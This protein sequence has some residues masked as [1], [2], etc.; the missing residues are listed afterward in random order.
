MSQESVNF[1]QYDGARASVTVD[2]KKKSVGGSFYRGETMN[3]SPL[4]KDL[5]ASDGLRKYLAHGW[6]PKEPFIDGETNIV[7]F[8]SCFAANISNYL[9]NIGYNVATKKDN[10]AYISKFGDGI[11]NT[12]ALLQQFE[13]A[14]K[15]KTPQTDLWHGY[16]AA[17]FGYDEAVRLKTKEIFDVADVFIITLGLSEVWYDEPTGEVFWRAV[18]AKMYDPSRHKFRVAE[19]D[20]SIENLRKIYAI[21]R[22]HRPESSIIFTLSPIALAATFRDQSCITS[23]ATSK[24]IL[25]AAID[26]LYREKSPADPKLFYFPSYEIVLECYRN[27]FG[28]DRRHVYPHVLNLNMKAFERFYCKSGV[29]D[30]D[31]D[32]TYAE[33][34]MI[35]E[36]LGYENTADIKAELAELRIE[37]FSRGAQKNKTIEMLTDKAEPGASASDPL[38][39]KRSAIR[40]DR[41]KTRKDEIRE[42]R[43]I[44][45]LE[46]RSQSNLAMKI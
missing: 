36:R 22:E 34:V 5:S 30:E 18:P 11:V 8:G 3:F 16:K 29:T 4:K 25:R 6:M 39:Q 35:D 43:R 1:V 45:K 33:S 7:A 46:S 15:N 20:E 26:R 27:Q 21:I 12:Y 42:Q 2:G 24:A 44:A 38:A 40:L 37:D 13:W 31:I 10:L 41:I 9:N 19:Y 23:N 14:W 17:E 28:H 32:Q